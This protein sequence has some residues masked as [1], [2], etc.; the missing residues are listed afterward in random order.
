MKIQKK[1]VLVAGLLVAGMLLF[2][3]CP[4]KKGVPDK[5]KVSIPDMTDTGGLTRLTILSL[6]K[7]TKSGTFKVVN[8][9]DSTAPVVTGNFQV[10]D[11]PPK[12][13]KLSNT[14]PVSYGLDG[15]HTIGGDNMVEIAASHYDL[16][17]L[18]NELP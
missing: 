4:Q 2:T 14:M 10:I 12:K 7:Q 9:M 15:D 17:P 6:D 18:L 5:N 8:L 13:L 1:A 16:T 3:G 11:G